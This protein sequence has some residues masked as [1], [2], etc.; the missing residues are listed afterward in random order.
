[1]SNYRLYKDTGR[2]ANLT[3]VNVD[4]DSTII[5]GPLTPLI[6]E[7]LKESGGFKTDDGHLSLEL[8]SGWDISISEQCARDLCDTSFSIKKPPVHKSHSTT[9]TTT[10]TITDNK[11]IDALDV[12]LGL[13]KYNK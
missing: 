3:I 2:F 6:V 10:K 8:Y 4:I 11:K 12:L 9:T 5:L 13:A 7:I 1:M